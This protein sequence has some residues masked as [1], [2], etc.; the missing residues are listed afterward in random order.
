MNTAIQL[1]HFCLT[2]AGIIGPG[3]APGMLARAARHLQ[4]AG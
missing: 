4:D 3:D 1:R 2:L